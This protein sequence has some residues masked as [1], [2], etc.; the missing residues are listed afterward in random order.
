MDNIYDFDHPRELFLGVDP[1][2]DTTCLDCGL[3][4]LNCDCDAAE[5]YFDHNDQYDTD[6]ALESVYGPTENYYEDY[7]EFYGYED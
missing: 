7:P 3:Y 2:E 6:S 1:A 5:E 4:F